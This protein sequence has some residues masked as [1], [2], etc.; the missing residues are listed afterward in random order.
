M[1]ELHIE[2]VKNEIA[3]TEQN[4]RGSNI[5]DVLPFASSRR[6]QKIKKDFPL[7]LGEYVRRICN[8]EIN[9]N[10]LRKIEKYHSEDSNELSE[11]IAENVEYKPLDIQ[12]DFVDFL[13]N[14]LFSGENIKVSHPYLYNFIVVPS[15]DKAEF[16]K[17]SN[18]LFDVFTIKNENINEIFVSKES[19]NIL[20]KL[21]LNNLDLLKESNKKQN[22]TY[23][24]F[25]KKISKLY[26]EDLLYLSNHRNYFLDNFA[27]LT[28]FYA[29]MY[30]CQLIMKFDEFTK[31][32]YEKVDPLYFC[33][34]WEKMGMRRKAAGEFRTYKYIN[35]KKGNLFPHIHTMSHLSHNSYNKCSLEKGSKIEILSYTKII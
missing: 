30:S 24:P 3:K 8:L 33:L 4:K 11:Y 28:N 21:L 32:N 12:H 17:V 34:S 7:V 13:N 27:L 22:I 18:F 6:I 23:T 35:N 20:M 2:K 31:A 29:F 16:N 1:R 26:I 10:E 9:R 25:F 19:N 14:T 5:T 15:K